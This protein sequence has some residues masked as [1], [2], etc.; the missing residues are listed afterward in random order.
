MIYLGLLA[1][2]VILLVSGD[3]L[4]RGSVSLAVKLGVPALVIGLTV[5]AFGTSAPELVVSVRAATTGAPGIAIGNIVG[6]NIANV[7]LVLGL[8]ALIRPT[9]CDHEFVGRNTC[10]MVG[11]TVIFMLFCYFGPLGFWHGSVLFGL[12]I[13]FLIESG[14]RAHASSTACKPAEVEEVEEVDGV[15]GLPRTP[16]MIG[17]FIFAGLIGLPF[18]AQL[19]VENGTEIA[20]IFHVSQTTIGLTIIALGTSLPELATT[21]SAAIR[22]HCAIAIGNV[23]GSNLFNMLAIMGLTAIVAPVPIPDVILKYDLWIML[24]ATLLIVPFVIRR[25]TIK[26][27]PA[28]GFVLAYCAYMFFVFTPNREMTNLVL[29]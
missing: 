10:Y 7:L 3:L 5:V 4:V 6:S 9:D 24:A 21:V 29:N 28:M 18:G 12:I 11:A 23:L 8:P 26:R 22:G 27:L 25:T 13:L 20:Q 19:I 17:V 2:F 1:G 15:S 16:S 14:R